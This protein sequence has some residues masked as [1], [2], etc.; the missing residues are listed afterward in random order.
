MFTKRSLAST[1]GKI[2][3]D[4]LGLIS[5]H[6]V[7]AKILLKQVH[8]RKIDWDGSLPEDLSQKY[9]S[10]LSDLVN[11]KRCTPPTKKFPRF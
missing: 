4:P 5:P 2:A 9:R 6:V 3:Y 1:V 8:E 10:W 11:L 7:T